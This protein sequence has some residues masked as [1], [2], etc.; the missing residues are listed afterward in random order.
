LGSFLRV[1]GCA[2]KKLSSVGLNVAGGGHFSREVRAENSPYVRDKDDALMLQLSPGSQWGD[3][4][5]VE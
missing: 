1:V 3:G 2:R 4:W 5:P